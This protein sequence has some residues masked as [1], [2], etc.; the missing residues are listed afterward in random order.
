[1]TGLLIENAI[2]IFTGRGGAAMRTQGSIRVRDGVIEAIGELEAE[3]GENRLDA[4]GCVIYPGLISTHHH[5]FQ[6]VMKGIKSGI[7]LPLAG[8]LG[9]VP[10]SSIS[11]RPMR[12]A[13]AS[14]SS[15]IFDQNAYGTARSQPASG[16]SMPVLIPFSTL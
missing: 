9:V 4:S 13:T 7:D 8:W 11:V 6:S 16:R 1:V 2:G 15:S 5:L 10:D 3:P 14:A 12:A